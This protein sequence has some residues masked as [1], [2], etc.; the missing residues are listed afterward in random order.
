MVQMLAQV[1]SHY[2]DD[3]KWYATAFEDKFNYVTAIGLL[4][5]QGADPNSI[6]IQLP[7]NGASGGNVVDTPS[8]ANTPWLYFL[9]KVTD[10]CI[11]RRDEDEEKQKR[12]PYQTITRATELLEIF[13]SFIISK[14]NLDASIPAVAQ[15]NAPSTASNV[16]SVGTVS[17]I[18]ECLNT[19]VCDPA[20]RVFQVPLQGTELEPFR[21]KYEQTL[22]MIREREKE[23]RVMFR[24]KSRLKSLM[25]IRLPQGSTPFLSF[26]LDIVIA[27]VIARMG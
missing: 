16:A 22:A 17:I 14:A 9:T 15:A 6:T 11:P 27:L 2:S 7:I 1:F 8:G 20:K 4:L 19:A 3:Y 24:V 5:G 12:D 21:T 10:I 26:I 25:E 13:Q 18:L 23:G